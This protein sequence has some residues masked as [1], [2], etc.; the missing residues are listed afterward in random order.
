MSKT[1]AGSNAQYTGASQSIYTVDDYVYG[2][3]GNIT[4]TGTG[5][6]DSTLLKFT[7]GKQLIKGKIDFNDNSTGGSDVYFRVTY[8]GVIVIDM[9]QGQEFLPLKYD[10]IIP[11]LTEVEVLWGCQ[12]NFVGNCFLTG[13]LYG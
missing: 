6:P 13:R 2:T 1:K 10:I 8:N 7:T 11:P 12:N 3:S 4:N 5:A 9:K